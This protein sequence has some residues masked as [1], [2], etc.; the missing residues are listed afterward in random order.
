MTSATMPNGISIDRTVW[1]KE[2]FY[3]VCFVWPSKRTA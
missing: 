3:V 2:A 1:N